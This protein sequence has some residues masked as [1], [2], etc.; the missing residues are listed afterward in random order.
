MKKVLLVCDKPFWAYGA[1]AN[2]LVK[3]NTSSEFDIDIY[4]LKEEPNN[5]EK[6]YKEYDLIFFMAW[7]LIGGMGLLKV[8][9]YYPKIN[10]QSCITGIHSHHAWDN[11]QSLPDKNTIPPKKL[12]RYLNRFRSI[13]TVSK[14]L[15]YLFKDS[16]VKSI[17]YTP[18]GVDTDIFK[19]MVPLELSGQI[20]IG[21]S[22]NTKSHDWRKGLTE[23]IIPAAE[24]SKV[25]LVT[26]QF[27]K[28]ELV[29]QKEMPA[30]YN[31]CDV[32]VCASSSEGFSLAV[33][34]AA[35]C[36][37][38]VISTR[39]GGCEDLIQDGE[40]GFLVDRNVDAICDK[41]KLLKNDKEL[42]V[43]MGNRSREIIEEKW[44]WEIRSKD[45]LDFIRSY[46]N[47]HPAP[48]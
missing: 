5:I 25:K 48:V 47:I 22:G 44:S 41:I 8:N 2:S 30:L 38:P 19:P 7:Q 6:V 23:F 3:Y 43:K 28:N 17:F 42:L 39:V 20:K 4:Y 33:L 14:R 9:N 15:Y 40:N 27:S 13:N 35:A 18:N 46:I 31:K 10:L 34:E 11:K 24:K 12:I 26:A 45:W 1:I 37:R 36:G 29:D 21:F 16:G 32:Y